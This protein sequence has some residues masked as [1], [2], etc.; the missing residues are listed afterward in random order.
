MIYLFYEEPDPDRWI[1]FDRY[2]R[3]YI[4]E[5][6]RGKTKPGGV[7]RWYLNLRRGLDLF[8]VDYCVNDYRRLKKH[9]N[10]W[11]CVVGKSHV[12]K[13]IPSSNPIMYGPGIDAHPYENDFLPK[14]NIKLMLISCEWFKQMYERDMSSSIATAVWPA[15]IETDIWQPPAEKPKTQSLLIYD[16]VRWRRD[17]YEPELIQ[18][19]R[20]QIESL[21]IKVEYLRYGFYEE[22]NYRKILQQVSGMIF[23][24]EHE[25]QGFAYLQALSSNVP[26]LAWDRGGYW[27]DPSMFPD[28]VKFEPVTSV[29]YFD[30]NCGERFTSITE[31]SQ[32]LQIFLDRISQNSYQPRQYITENFD[33]V[34]QAKAYLNLLKQAQNNDE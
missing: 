31:F 33:L 18:P 25:T 20:N 10:A 6:I 11:A 2:P 13:K 17:E 14:A 32:Q 5:L 29:P 28:R 16:K 8:G 1:K 26:I 27:Q 34:E 22:E 19:I 12:L 30:Q 9:P 3:K 21:G 24:C 15:G 23:L 4:R 7:M